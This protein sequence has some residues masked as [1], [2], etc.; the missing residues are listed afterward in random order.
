MRTKP[1][2]FEL[3]TLK[4][5][6]IERVLASTSNHS[7]LI[8]FYS[9]FNT[10]LSNEDQVL[11]E[12]FLKEFI[13]D[14]IVS[15]KKFDVFGINPEFTDKLILQLKNLTSLAFIKNVLPEL[16]FEI[17]RIEKQKKKLIHILEGEEFEDGIG[18]KAFFPLIDKEASEDFYGII[19]FVTIIINKASD[20]DK[21]IIVP[22]EKEIE[23]KISEQCNKSW[24]L[25]VNI[26][27]KYVKK[28]YK[29][30]KVII[31]FDKREG[32]YAGNSL[33]IALTLS[34]L[35]ELL[36]F[37]NPTYVIKI[38]EQ[39][40]FTGG[41][42]VS[43]DVLNV[44]DDIIK[45]KVAAIFFSE[46]NSFVIPKQ[47]ETYAFFYLT[48]LKK[49]HPKRNLRII[50]A[51]DIYDVLK[52]RNLVEIKKI[53]PI[54]RSG[55]FVKKNWVS[56]T[57]VILL[58]ILFTYL[59]TVDFDDNPTI[60]AADG[61]TLFIKNKNDKILWTKNITLNEKD[62]IRCARIIDI[63]GDGINEVILTYE[64]D[65][66]N[67]NPIDNSMV[68]CYN[69]DAGLIWKYSFGD[70]VYSRREVLNTEYHLNII[71]TLTFTKEKSLFL[72]SSNGP[73]FSSAIFR[74]DLRT[75]QRLP[76]TFWASGH[77]I[78]CK[79]KDI[80]KDNKPE[81]IGVGYDNGYEDAVFFIYVVDTLTKVR[82]TKEEYSI[83]NH[84]ISLMKSYIRFP[85]TDYDIYCRVRTPTLID[86]QLT[87][88]FKNRSYN[89]GVS[90]PTTGYEPEL[91]YRINYNFKDI[92]IVIQSSYR[93]QRDTLVA[94]GILKPPYT[95]TEEYKNLIKSKILFW[96][97]GE[98]VKRKDLD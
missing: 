13:D 19:E 31:S 53:N 8:H 6:L 70:T 47:E 72:I 2:I 84:P 3:E 51:A 79:I 54:V 52:R 56:A 11:S 86:A 90:N 26:L 12:A 24:L 92:D 10:I 58:T 21:F 88:D 66:K 98:W 59:F 25:A 27:K 77:I 37:Y 94:H 30:H 85:K 43:G 82:P 49:Q 78:D 23:K 65:K 7:R 62:L 83:I 38:K 33:G 40:A 28:P 32:F 41:I 15:I 17:E 34:F 20:S 22:S 91:Q 64:S 50:P 42:D 1:N 46:M 73:S 89:F 81:M 9:Y 80:N 93:V 68:S 5:E 39:S 18:N 45:Q 36:K 60:L 57:I 29:Y 35:K 16:T 63:D 87:D 55:K 97:N 75:G 76:G 74:I 4:N 67:G 96:E 14:Y 44:G 48:Q 69:K 71:D 61:S 95:D